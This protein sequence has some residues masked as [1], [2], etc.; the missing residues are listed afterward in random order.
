M[1]FDKTPDP[2]WLPFVE[3]VFEGIY[4]VMLVSCIWHLAYSIAL[5]KV[6]Q[7]TSFGLPEVI[8]IAGVLAAGAQLSNYLTKRQ[9]QK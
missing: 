2:G 8:K 7:A 6:E 4:K 3:A 5:G 1:I 9:E